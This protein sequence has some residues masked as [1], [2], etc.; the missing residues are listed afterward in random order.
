IGDRLELHVAA[1]DLGIGLDGQD[2]TATLLQHEK[3]IQHFS[4]DEQVRLLSKL[5]DL[6]YR[7]G[8]REE[9]ERLTHELANRPLDLPAATLVL[10]PVLQSIDDSLQVRLINN[11]RRLEGDDGTWWRYGEA[12]RQ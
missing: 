10:D 6:H 1:L 12:M 11:L 7:F 8:N 2:A 5:A 3:A 4:P 9:G